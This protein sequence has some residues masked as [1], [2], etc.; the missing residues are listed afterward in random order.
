VDD[1]SSVICGNA[2]T[3]KKMKSIFQTTRQRGREQWLAQQSN[4]KKG[5]TFAAFTCE[6]VVVK[7][8]GEYS[9][10][11]DRQSEK[12]S[13]SHKFLGTFTKHLFPP[14]HAFSIH[15]V[16]STWF[17]PVLCIYCSCLFFG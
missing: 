11:A 10:E 9:Q 4:K 1:G 16:Y 13:Q 5:K 8:D 17:M 15:F 12:E 3:K 7:M 6:E 2:F 14:L